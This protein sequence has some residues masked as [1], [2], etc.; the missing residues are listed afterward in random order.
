MLLITWTFL[1]GNHWAAERMQALASFSTLYWL[2]FCATWLVFA[3]ANKVQ[4]M[5]WHCFAAFILYSFHRILQFVTYDID[6]KWLSLRHLAYNWNLTI[7]IFL[8]R[9][10]LQVRQYV[11]DFMEV[12]LPLCLIFFQSWTSVTITAYG[13]LLLIQILEKFMIEPFVAWY[14][15]FIQHAWMLGIVYKEL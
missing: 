2:H 10:G 12:I 8:V 15:W 5:G 3:M 13:N 11:A 4:I 1:C 7:V 14:M 9:Q 6:N